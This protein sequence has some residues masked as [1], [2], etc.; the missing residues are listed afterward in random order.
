[1]TDNDK[2]IT[3]GK[4]LSVFLYLSELFMET[5]VFLHQVNQHISDSSMKTAAYVV[6]AVYLLIR[7][8]AFYLIIVKRK[9]KMIIAVILLACILSVAGSHFFRSDH[10][11]NSFN[12]MIRVYNA[13]STNVNHYEVYIDTYLKN[14]DV[15]I[16]E[17]SSQES[18]LS[19]ANR[20]IKLE[21]QSFN[22]IV[23]DENYVISDEISADIQNNKKYFSSKYFAYANKTKYDFVVYLYAGEDYEVCQE[24][25]MCR[26][27]AGNLYFVPKTFW[28]EH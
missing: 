19:D 8:A 25:V 2:K 14:K 17:Y 13:P 23:V 5:C 10:K 24:I 27:Y 7:L 1:M 28:E 16:D 12:Y 9:T 26:D 15:Y 6:F 20:L 11:P 21:A 22:R 4:A 18:L 3:W